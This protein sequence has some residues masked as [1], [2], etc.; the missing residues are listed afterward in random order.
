MTTT[1]KEPKSTLDKLKEVFSKNNVAEFNRQ[2]LLFE[3]ADTLYIQY[4]LAAN[5]DPASSPAAKYIQNDTNR[6]NPTVV[7][8]V[9]LPGF[10]DVDANKKYLPFT[11][12]IEYI[13]KKTKLTDFYSDGTSFRNYFNITPDK[14][15]HMGHYVFITEEL[16]SKTKGTIEE[17]IFNR[18]DPKYSNSY[19]LDPTTGRKGGAGIQ[20]INVNYEGI[21]SETKRIV[22]VN[23]KFVFQDASEMLKD[24]YLKLFLLDTKKE[25]GGVAHRRTIN[26]NIGWDS[27]A[28]EKVGVNF[29]NLKLKLRTNLVNYNINLNQDGS[30]I[31]D[32]TYR[33]SFI[34]TLSSSSANVL[35]FSKAAAAK[36]KND[37][38]E[39]ERNA[40]RI[41]GESLEVAKQKRA[42]LLVLEEF[43]NQTA[44]H[45]SG[46]RVGAFSTKEISDIEQ[47][48]LQIFGE[49]DITRYP[50]T[51]P[52]DGALERVFG[53]TPATQTKALQKLGFETRDSRVAA[54]R[55]IQEEYARLSQS[56]FDK[57]I[58]NTTRKEATAQE[59]FL[60]QLEEATKRINEIRRE[61]G[62]ASSK[63]SNALGAATAEAVKQA[64]LAKL[65]ALREIGKKLIESS[66]VYYLLAKT[67]N[68]EASKFIQIKAPEAAATAPAL[69]P[70]VRV[71]GD[72]GPFNHIGPLEEF[73][74]FDGVLDASLDIDEYQIIP[75]V[76]FGDVIRSVLERIPAGEKG[77]VDL[78][79][80]DLISDD[81]GDIRVDFGMISYRT[82]FVGVPIKNFPIYY[83]PISLVELNNFFNREV[84]SKGR[85]FYS[86][87]DLIT[88]M[89]KKFLGGAFEQSSRESGTQGFTPP[90][91][92]ILN[93]T[94]KDFSV[95]ENGVLRTGDLK[96]QFA[97]FDQKKA[98]LTTEHSI[99][100]VFI[101]SA[102]EAGIDLVVKGLSPTSEGS[103]FGNFASNMDKGVPHFYFLGVDRGIEKNIT[104]TDI[105][106]QS[107][108]AAVYYSSKSSLVTDAITS[109]KLYKRTGIP[110]AVFQAEIETIGF[111][112]FN[113]GQMIYIDL[114]NPEKVRDAS[115]MLKASG[116]YSI[117]K[118]SHQITP[119]TFS[120]NIT[121]IIQVPYSDREE[122]T[123][124]ATKTKTEFD[125]KAAKRAAEKLKVTARL[126]KI[127]TQNKESKDSYERQKNRLGATEAKL[128]KEKEKFS[129][130]KTYKKVVQSREEFKKAQEEEI[131]E[132]KTKNTKRLQKEREKL[133]KKHKLNDG[134][135]EEELRKFIIKEIKKT[136]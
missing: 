110:P 107:V 51:R 61:E 70:Y 95:P 132:Y 65:S 96:K 14:I 25:V 97:G 55:I 36:V 135:V 127:Q 125:L 93:T 94:T 8:Q 103:A 66:N 79:V 39:T 131:K 113:I 33:G 68:I 1:T 136:K 37:V 71:G 42:L 3:N 124:E 101:Y 67:S 30:I 91:L 108:K 102:K 28:P 57:V 16:T 27:N 45:I 85:E 111:P 35:E 75:Y 49:N 18:Y 20:S 100:N 13:E 81:G 5:E 63:A 38:E 112:L 122:I 76:F 89:C 46:A 54:Y 83:M 52:F 118:V 24:P 119:E 98:R 9:G 109:N 130:S 53:G 59:F 72:R 2:T 123:E 121:A 126:E 62:D 84:V 50:S 82:P 19:I 77:G 69:A 60:V 64:N 44:E 133:E 43:R 10:I 99:D 106:D 86:V 134:K 116:Y 12:N 17:T 22:M 104:L 11:S 128:S 105:A 117:Y 47:F 32:A 58:T 74:G 21:D 4:I 56:I 73:S 48:R 29:D 88:D 115:R 80:Y 87:S 129:K 78:Y 6:E 23:A 15:A 120:S 90:K 40:Q 92:S 114:I 31:V 34:E 41:A 7:R 26:F